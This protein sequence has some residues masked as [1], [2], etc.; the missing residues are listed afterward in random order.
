[1]VKLSDGINFDEYLD[2]ANEEQKKLFSLCYENTKLSEETINQIKDIKGDII[3]LIF[4]ENYC[5]DCRVT[6]PFIKKM[7]EYNGKIKTYIFPLRGYEKVLKECTGDA[8]VP[9]VM[10][11]NK[12]MESKG[13]YIEMPEK[14]KEQLIGVT[15]AQKREI[16]SKYREGYYNDFIE[17][18]LLNIFR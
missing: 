1:M 8:Y 7:Q 13:L 14:L 10:T 6:L 11:F 15:I 9:T 18:Q 4:S 2:N 5:P 17:Q 3:V 12:Y 16:I